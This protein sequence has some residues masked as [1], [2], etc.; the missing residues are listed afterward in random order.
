M[1]NRVV[2]LT[3]FLKDNPTI[4]GMTRGRVYEYE[5]PD[6][7]VSKMPVACLVLSPSGSA[8]AFGG[9]Y[10]QFSDGRIDIT[11]YAYTVP[12]AYELYQAVYAVL[13]PMRRT[14]VGDTL[15][16]WCR[17]AGGPVSIRSAEISWPGMAPDPS[18]HWPAVTASWQVLSADIAPAPQPVGA[19]I[20]GGAPDTTTFD[21]AI[22][23]GDPDTSTFDDAI[24]GGS[25]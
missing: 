1:P 12:S 15:L 16:H 18:L 22:D 14:L 4:G 7:Q 2:A 24:D 13:K 5:M 23:G 25:P 20:D 19:G 9:G 21:D 17:K 6:S 3:H 11:H 10:Q 8:E